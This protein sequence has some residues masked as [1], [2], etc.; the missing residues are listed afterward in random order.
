MTRRQPP[1]TDHRHSTN[2]SLQ[3]P[4]YR[5][6]LVPTLVHG[7]GQYMT[8][9]VR[10]ISRPCHHG[11]ASPRRKG[12]GQ[13]AGE[14]YHARYY[15]GPRSSTKKPCPA[16]LSSSRS[17][18]DSVSASLALRSGRLPLRGL[19]DLDFLRP[20]GPAPRPPL[21]I[22][23]RL[24]LPVR[25]LLPGEFERPRA[26]PRLDRVGDKVSSQEMT[27]RGCSGR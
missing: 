4:R 15:L 18:P 25:R 8:E 19:R 22:D 13:G 7:H 11:M 24:A 3:G 9:V 14:I 5:P 23:S 2:V 26:S 12:K 1:C 27:G 10:S 21:P 20:R 17:S 16:P 6:M